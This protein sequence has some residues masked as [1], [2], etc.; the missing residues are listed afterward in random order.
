MK[1]SV[2]SLLAAAR[3]SAG[4]ARLLTDKGYFRIAASR[5]YYAMFYVARAYLAEENLTYSSHSAVIAAFG[6]LFIKTGRIPK[7]FQQYL[8]T[9]QDIRLIGDYSIE[10]NVEADEALESIEHAEAFLVLAEKMLGEPSDDGKPS[11]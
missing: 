2:E 9:G 3:E 8:T 6:K 5:A 10:R 7:V 11:G 4:A 1:S